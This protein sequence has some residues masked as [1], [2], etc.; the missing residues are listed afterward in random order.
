[1]KNVIISETDRIGDVILT[2]PV[3]KTIKKFDK[4]IKITALVKSYTAEIFDNFKFIDDIIIFGP[5]IKNDK[6]RFSNLLF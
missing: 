2:L 1:M 6:Q 5:I 3:F 4:N